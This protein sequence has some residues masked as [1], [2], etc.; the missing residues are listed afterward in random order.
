MVLT[1]ATINSHAFQI[2][3]VKKT[4]VTSERVHP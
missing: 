2:R 4:V 3:Q 1:Y